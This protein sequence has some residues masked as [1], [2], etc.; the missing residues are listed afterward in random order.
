M[1][2]TVLTT[3]RN[4]TEALDLNEVV[5]EFVSWSQICRNKFGVQVQ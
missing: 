5:T 1:I 3:H 2:L 4:E